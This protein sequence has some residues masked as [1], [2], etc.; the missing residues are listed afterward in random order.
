[1]WSQN[2][3]VYQRGEQFHFTAAVSE[4]GSAWRTVAVDNLSSGGLAFQDDQEYAR[5]TVLLFDILVEGLMTEF[6]VNARGQVCWVKPSGERYAY[7]IAFLDL[8]PD[9]GIRIDENVLSVKGMGIHR[10]GE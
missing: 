2:K 10:L 3:R 9:V 6:H 4:D 5:A 8:D 7:G 1:M